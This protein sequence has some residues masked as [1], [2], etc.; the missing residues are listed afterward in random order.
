MEE[1]PHSKGHD[2][3]LQ[4]WWH[5]EDSPAD[6]NR[7]AH[8]GAHA[9]RYDVC[10]ARASQGVLPRAHYACSHKALDPATYCHYENTRTST[11]QATPAAT[12]RTT[13]LPK[14]QLQSFYRDIAPRTPFLANE[15]YTTVVDTTRA[16]D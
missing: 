9:G 3:L 11:P 4:Q 14:A 16:D 5:D 13:S 8:A 6:T 1:S 2:D 12:R 7:E 10:N 15:T